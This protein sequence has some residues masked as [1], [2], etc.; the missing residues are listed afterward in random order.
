MNT[1]EWIKKTIAETII[2]SGG[3]PQVEPAVPNGA[4][5]F[6]P[7]LDARIQLK[8]ADQAVS[9]LDFEKFMALLHSVAGDMGF[10][11]AQDLPKIASLLN[12]LRLMK[13]LQPL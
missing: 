3:L 12:E 13:N 10:N 4:V 7:E 2:P 5:M 11:P 6:S 1:L 8:Y 9:D